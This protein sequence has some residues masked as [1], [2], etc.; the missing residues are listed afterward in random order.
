MVS[1]NLVKM[2]K[3]MKDGRSNKMVGIEDGY[4][5]FDG[6][7]ELDEGETDDFK[8]LQDKLRDI[9]E[10]YI[11]VN[12]TRDNFAKLNSEL[13]YVMLNIRRTTLNLLLR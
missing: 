2:I 8:S 13:E 11:G 9:R 1:K 12:L 4:I 10:K 3:I 6:F 7:V 5:N